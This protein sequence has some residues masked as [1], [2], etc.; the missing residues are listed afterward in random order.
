M[1]VKKPI[2]LDETGKNMVQEMAKQNALLQILAKD[3][4][5]TLTDD[6]GECAEDCARR[7]RSSGI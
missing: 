7:I 5:K 6:W 1:S 2:I 4:I 3:S